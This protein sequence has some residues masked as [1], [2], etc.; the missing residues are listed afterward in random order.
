V[1]LPTGKTLFNI[2]ANPGIRITTLRAQFGSILKKVGAHQQSGVVR[3]LSDI[4]IGIGS[5][6]LAAG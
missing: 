2:A 6:S 4:G 3:I 5:V 1:A